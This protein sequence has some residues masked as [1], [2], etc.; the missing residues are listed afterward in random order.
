MI[1]QARFVPEPDHERDFEVEH[2]QV[3]L[4]RRSMVLDHVG[5]QRV[6]QVPNERPNGKWDLTYST[7]YEAL[8]AEGH[9]V[10]DSDRK[11]WWLVPA[12]YAASF[13]DAWARAE[14]KKAAE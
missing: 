4:R 11:G 7:S 8:P 6:V 12:K 5:P 14:A 2:F 13:A 10:V 1:P 9:V 3:V